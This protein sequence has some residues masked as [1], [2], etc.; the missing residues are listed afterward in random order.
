MN[1]LALRVRGTF[2]STTK[3]APSCKAEGWIRGV[4]VEAGKLWKAETLIA[5]PMQY[6]RIFATL[7]GKDIAD[8]AHIDAFK[9]G[10]DQEEF[11]RSRA[12][13]APKNR[14]SQLVTMT[15]G[16]HTIRTTSRPRQP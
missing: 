5:A 13:G 8:N 2:A 4:D 9:E 15:C 12:F 1:R 10:T 3:R 6:V 16:S 14:P 7:D 11:P